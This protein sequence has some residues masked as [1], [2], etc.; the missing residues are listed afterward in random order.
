[1]KNATQAFTQKKK[2]KKTRLFLLHSNQ[3][4]QAISSCRESSG[5]HKL[6]WKSMC[7]IRICPQKKEILPSKI[8]GEYYMFP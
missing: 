5:G 6:H 2:K 3:T 8:N 4:G 7:L 1:M